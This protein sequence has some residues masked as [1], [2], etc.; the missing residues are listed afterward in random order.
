MYAY[1]FISQLASCGIV[2]CSRDAKFAV[3]CDTCKLPYCLVCLASGTKD[4]C[5]RCGCRTSK[6]VEQLV[7]LRLKSIYKAF[8]QSGAALGTKSSINEGNEKRLAKEGH[9]ISTISAEIISGDIS[10]ISRKVGRGTALSIPLPPSIAKYAKSHA[11]DAEIRNCTVSNDKRCIRKDDIGAVMHAAAATAASVAHVRSASPDDLRN[12][13]MSDFFFNTAINPSES[14]VSSHHRTRPG[15]AIIQTPHLVS[16][17]GKTKNVDSLENDTRTLADAD[18]AAAALLAELDEEKL[19]TEASN[20]AK[21]DKKKKKKEKLQAAKERDKPHNHCEKYSDHCKTEA[22]KLNDQLLQ[23]SQHSNTVRDIDGSRKNNKV[24]DEPPQSTYSSVP[25]DMLDNQI[26]ELETKL[27]QMIELNDMSG[28]ETILLQ[29]KGVPGRAAIRKNAKKA[30]KRIMES[31]SAVVESQESPTMESL[32]QSPLS[33]SPHTSLKQVVQC[34]NASE[35]PS[36]SPI[37]KIPEPLLKV[38]SQNNRN[39]SGYANNSVTNRSDCVMHLHPSIV[40]WVIGRGGQ[41]I[42]DLMEESGA[43]LWIDQESMG[44]KDMRIIYVSGSRKSVDTAV[45]MVKDLVSKAPVYTPSTA[46][47]LFH[48]DQEKGSIADTRSDLRT[49]SPYDDL[50]MHESTGL[51]SNVNLM[52]RLRNDQSHIPLHRE[53]SGTKSTDHNNGI[54]SNNVSMTLLDYPENSHEYKDVISHEITC[55]V[56]YVPLLIGRR[57]WTIKHI[58]DTSGARVDIDQTASPIKIIVSG[59]RSQVEQ[60]MQL[61]RDVLSY[62]QVH[63]QASVESMMS[64]D[65]EATAHVVEQDLGQGVDSARGIQSQPLTGPFPNQPMTR[66]PIAPSQLRPANVSLISFHTAE[67]I[68]SVGKSSHSLNVTHDQFN[69]YQSRNIISSD[70][71]PPPGIFPHS[72][73]LPIFHP[74]QLHAFPLGHNSLLPSFHLNNQTSEDYSQEQLLPTKGD[75]ISSHTQPSIVFPHNSSRQDAMFTMSSDTVLRTKTEYHSENTKVTSVPS[76]ISFHGSKLDSEP[77]GLAGGIFNA[78]Q[79]RIPTPNDR[80]IIDGLF[81]PDTYDLNDNNDPQGH[82]SPLIA[83]FTSAMNFDTS[84]QGNV[85]DQWK[86]NPLRQHSSVPLSNIFPSKAKS[87]RLSSDHSVGLGGVKLDL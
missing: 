87:K 11:K 76:S 77:Y 68:S 36:E 66:L 71:I 14:F 67:A 31:L 46:Q 69:Q 15:S 16:S 44:P 13:S 72:P 8:K 57:G 38:V 29:L 12:E 41:R 62:P 21:K 73:A 2:L 27:A 25:Q 81:G 32:E 20:Q 28:I 79:S 56:R 80:D 3:E 52:T 85:N 30:L 5:V 47:D 55:D 22:Q 34:K 82:I 65:K 33:G 64:N 86:W 23:V 37:Y 51:F 45:R 63:L 24:T 43:R 6:R 53:I 40:G 58:Q 19:M 60:A 7:H 39:F 18:A 35:S 50:G 26:D 83:E 74:D 70:L 78:S 4:P 1:S 17:K 59:E 10:Q 49:V 84:F 75:S 48:D 61:V 54:S 42:R 9:T